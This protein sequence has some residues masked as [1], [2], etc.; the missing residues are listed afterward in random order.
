MSQGEGEKGEE[1]RGVGKKGE[2]KRGEP[3]A[4]GVNM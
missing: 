2:E 3:R 4:Q 1:K